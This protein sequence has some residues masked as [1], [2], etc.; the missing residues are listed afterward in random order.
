MGPKNGPQK[1]TPKT[2]HCSNSIQGLLLGPILGTQFWV[3]VLGLFSGVFWNPNFGFWCFLSFL[4]PSRAC[5]HIIMKRVRK[6][7]RGHSF[8]RRFHLLK[9]GPILGTKNN[10]NFEPDT[11]QVCTYDS[12]YRPGSPDRPCFW[13]VCWTLVLGHAGPIITEQQP[14]QF[15][16]YFSSWFPGL[17]SAFLS[18]SLEE[19][20]SVCIDFA[21]Q[22]VK[23]FK[24]SMTRSQQTPLQ[25]H[26]AC[27]VLMVFKVST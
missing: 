9:Q 6:H 27:H 10:V 5:S 16:C 2:G 7:C 4:L 8:R 19:V 11:C 14:Y 25:I 3:P 1:W 24:V 15:V 23:V 20:L 17:V 18:G 12:V 22:V 21:C 13:W 26:R